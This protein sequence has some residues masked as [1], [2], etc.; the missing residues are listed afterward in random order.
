MKTAQHWIDRLDEVNSERDQQ[1]WVKSIHKD[2]RKGMSKLKAQNRR[3]KTAIRE[4]LTEN[5]HLADG[6]VCTLIK[7]KL[8]TSL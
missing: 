6:D 4:T 3:M 5:A 2:A 8:A 1:N 7:L